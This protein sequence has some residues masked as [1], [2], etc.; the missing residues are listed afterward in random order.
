MYFIK[1]GLS[2]KGVNV[3][4]NNMYLKSFHPLLDA[5]IT[6]RDIRVTR[7]INITHEP[8]EGAGYSG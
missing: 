3:M 8:V 1:T 2:I 5:T 6:I 7:I 4:R